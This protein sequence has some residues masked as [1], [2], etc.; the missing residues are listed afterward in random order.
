M[1]LNYL[2]LFAK[3]NIGVQNCIKPNIIRKIGCTYQVLV[4][5][6]LYR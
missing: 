1:K 4:I 6:V 5:S 2:L 3:M